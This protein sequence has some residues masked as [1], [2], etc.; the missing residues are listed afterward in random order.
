MLLITAAAF[1]VLLASALF[2]TAPSGQDSFTRKLTAEWHGTIPDSYRGYRV[3]P[4]GAGLAVPELELA[5]ASPQALYREVNTL[6]FR[7]ASGR[8]D[9]AVEEQYAAADRN[10]DGILSENEIE[11]FVRS[12]SA[13]ERGVGLSGLLSYWGIERPL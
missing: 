11:R 9:Y 4:L 6:L 13:G 5:A 1:L 7:A 10:G 2:G 8:V 12:L 3:V